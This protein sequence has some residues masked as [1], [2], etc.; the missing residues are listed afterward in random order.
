M[1]SAKEL[2]Q[3]EL[4]KRHA[5]SQTDDDKMRRMVNDQEKI[6]MMDPSYRTD[7]SPTLAFYDSINPGSNLSRG[8]TK[9]ESTQDALRK[10]LNYRM[11]Q[12][13]TSQDKL[14]GLMAKQEAAELK[15][16]QGR[17]LSANDVM[18][19]QEG[20]N[21]PMMLEDVGEIVSANAGIFGPIEGRLHGVNPWDTQ[22]KTVDAQM[23]A[24]SQAFGRFM[25]G[26]VL[27]KEDE[28]KYRKMFPSLSDTPSVA[29]NKLEVVKRLMQQ[30]QEGNVNALSQAGFDTSMF[31]GG[32]QGA[33]I[34]QTGQMGQQPTNGGIDPSNMSDA[35]LDAMISRLSK[36]R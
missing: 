2:L 10:A 34:V 23:R 1:A 12:P 6:A 21:I 7:M 33:P 35:D 27:R 13:R 22:G 24:A 15:A 20:E 36:G 31:A 8:Y 11:Q 9:P 29:T 14:L 30:R 32:G 3:A 18:K 19:V 25:E 4:L 28:E 5:Q 16:A 17:Q 26:G